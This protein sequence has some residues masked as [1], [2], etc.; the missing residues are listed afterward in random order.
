MPKP[1]DKFYCPQ[2]VISTSKRIRLSSIC[3]MLLIM[4]GVQLNPGLLTRQGSVADQSRDY[5][6]KILMRQ[7]SRQL[8]DNMNH[9]KTEITNLRTAMELKHDKLEN[10]LKTEKQ[11]IKI[12]LRS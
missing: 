4:S 11:D 9:L 5:E 1:K 6:I 10:K 3:V 12:W 2:M 7:L 8:N